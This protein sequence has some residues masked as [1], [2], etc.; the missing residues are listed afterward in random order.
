MKS[1]LNIEETAK[2]YNLNEAPELKEELKA[3]DQFIWQDC[4]VNT[5][6]ELVAFEKQYQELGKNLGSCFDSEME[7]NSFV[8]MR[9]GKMC[10]L[11]KGVFQRTAKGNGEPYAKFVA[12]GLTDLEA[13]VIITFLAEISGLYRKDAYHYDIP[14][15]VQ[16]V[17][18]ILNSAV[19][20]LPTFTGMVVRACNECDKADFSVGDVF[21]PGFCLTCSADLTWENKSE[22]RYRIQPLK[23]VITRARN[24]HQIHNI[25]EE[26]VTFLQDAQFCITDIKDWGDGNKEFW[27]E[28]R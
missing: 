17:C 26:Q 21:T 14:P 1:P 10:L 2:R 27:M 11:E 19:S 13:V 5:V 24:L 16:A 28:E 3:F 25:S 7:E 9:D 4:T 18:E 22:N 12:A 8:Y 23:A 20:K 15:F 6:A